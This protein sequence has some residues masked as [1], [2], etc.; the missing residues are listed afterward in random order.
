LEICNPNNTV[1]YWCATPFPSG[2]SGNITNEPAFRNAAAGDFRLPIGSPCID[3]GTN[4]SGFIANDLDGNTRPLDGNADGISA[5]D[6]GAY[7]YDPRLVDSD[8]DGAT[9]FQEFVADTNPTNALSLFRITAITYSPTVAVFFTSSSRR[10]YTLLYRTNLAAG[11]PSDFVWT[12]V[13]GQTNVPGSGGVDAL[14]DT[15]A[16]APRF[17]RVRAR[18]P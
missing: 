12:P 17:Y 9:D 6:I 18:L 13:A 10:R 14:R 15:N 2:G 16:T 11:K 1:T 8:H 5:F 3:A 4:L 7:E